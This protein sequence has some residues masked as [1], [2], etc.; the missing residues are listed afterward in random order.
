MN[1]SAVVVLDD[2]RVESILGFSLPMAHDR[3]TA[4]EAG[5]PS[6][7]VSKTPAGVG[8]FRA[9]AS[10]GR[11]QPKP[12]RS[13][14][15][16]IAVSAS[17]L[18]DMLGG[19]EALAGRGARRVTGFPRCNCEGDQKIATRW[20]KQA[21]ED[22]GAFIKEMYGVTPDKLDRSDRRAM[23][24][25]C[26]P[27]LPED[28]LEMLVTLTGKPSKM[29]WTEFSGKSKSKTASNTEPLPDNEL[30]DVLKSRFPHLAKTKKLADVKLTPRDRFTI[31]NTPALT[32][33]MSDE[34][35]EAL[36]I[37][38]KTRTAAKML[39]PKMT[40]TEAESFI[41]KTFKGVSRTKDTGRLQITGPNARKSWKYLGERYAAQ[42]PQAFLDEY[43]SELMPRKAGRKPGSG[44][45]T[46]P[47]NREGRLIEKPAKVS[48][49]GEVVKEKTDAQKQKERLARREAKLKK[50]GIDPAQRKKDNAERNKAK[51]AA[52]KKPSLEDALVDQFENEDQ[53]RKDSNGEVPATVITDPEKLRRR[54]NT[55]SQKID[56]KFLFGTPFEKYSDLQW[57]LMDSIRDSI[58]PQL[59]Q[60]FKPQ[61][62]NIR[63]K[64]NR[65]TGGAYESIIDNKQL[66]LAHITTAWWCGE[67]D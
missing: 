4:S 38:A 21:K 19:S 45:R 55:M 3:V 5:T 35:L 56:N 51:P 10:W 22:T 67:F 17:E 8:T 62:D 32:R 26:A 63:L 49:P 12:T 40:L 47:V 66:A 39:S 24:R 27:F 15:M 50:Q 59:L 61:L 60:K 46:G 11:E 28:K 44:T 30:L 58:S 23:K 64:R 25:D 6:P 33:R 57:A 34:A 9:M 42:L 53:S 37:I 16:H 65:A 54:I 29:F 13:P 41:L 36:G 20:R 43:A 2:S 48:R 1:P 52:P 14:N 31:R 7:S 18:R